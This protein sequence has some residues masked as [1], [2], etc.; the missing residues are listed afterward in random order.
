MASAQA[1]EALEIVREVRRLVDLLVEMF[2]PQTNGDKA[3]GKA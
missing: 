2:E 1:K 3:K